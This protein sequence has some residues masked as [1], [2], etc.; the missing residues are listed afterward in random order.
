MLH[1]LQT[2]I[3]VFLVILLGAA[4]RALGFLTAAVAGPLNRLVYYVAIPAM[5]LNALAEASFTAHFQ[6]ALLAATLAPLLLMFGAAPALGRLF[7]IPRREMGTFVQSSFHGNL[8]YIGFAVVFYLLGP[9]GFTSASI[10]AGFLMLVQ[11]FLGVIVLQRFSEHRGERFGLMTSVRSVAANPVILSTLAG[12]AWSLSGLSLP[13]IASRT[14]K[15][16][17][18]MSLPMALLVIGASLSFGLVR[19]NLRII[20]PSAFLK[21]V[22]LPA[23]GLALFE[24]LGITIRDFLPGFIL[25][26]APTATVT[27]V[28]ASE[29]DGSPGQASAAVSLCT[30]LSSLSYIAWLSI[31]T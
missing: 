2:I 8:G 11:N 23:M 7:S 28:M 27:Y 14:L 1:I 10:L 6:P 21:L 16:V 20:L 12:I 19:S 15:I 31:L 29:L 26:A 24:I 30:L 18:G 3:P 9:E 5:I 17:A 25:L 22:V 4:L 13:V